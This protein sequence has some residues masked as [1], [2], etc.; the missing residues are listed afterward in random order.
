MTSRL[1]NIYSLYV[2]NLPWTVDKRDMLTYFSQFGPVASVKLRYVC[3]LILNSL[4][5]MTKIKSLKKI[6]G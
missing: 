2:K 1:T 3:V 5:F 4:F 6:K